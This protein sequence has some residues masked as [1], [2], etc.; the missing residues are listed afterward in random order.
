MGNYVGIGF[1]L[2]AKVDQVIPVRHLCRGVQYILAVER[3]FQI[4]V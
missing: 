2:R 1:L 3:N 4:C